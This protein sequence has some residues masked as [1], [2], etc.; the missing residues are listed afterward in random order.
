MPQ[1]LT[2]CLVLAGLV[3]PF[4]GMVERCSADEH[5]ARWSQPSQSDFFSEPPAPDEMLP[6]DF[7]LTSQPKEEGASQE[8]DLL[9]GL[10]PSPESA[11]P[12][13]NSHRSG[14]KRQALSKAAAGAY[15]DP[16]YDNDFNYLN[17]PCYDGCLLGERFK[18]LHLPCCDECTTLDLGGQYRL[19]FHDEMNMRGLGLTGQDDQFLLRRLRLYANWQVSENLR[20]YGE[21]LDARSDFEDLSPRP[22]EE[23]HHELQ[24]LFVDL[25]MFASDQGELWARPGRQ[26]LIYGSQRLISPLDW[27]NTRRTFDG[28]KIYYRGE[29]WN[30]DGFWV[31]PMLGEPQSLDSPD[32]TQELYALWWNYHGVENSVFDLFW[33]GYA[34]YDSPFAAANTFQFQTVG[35][36]WKT[37]HGQWLAEVEGG[38]Q[39][40]DFGGMNH[41]AGFFTIG[42]GR[43]M[44]NLPCQPVL[45]AYYD[46]ASG[47][48]TI[49][50]GFNQLFPLGHKY[51]GFMDFFAR[52]NIED[53]N[54][55]LETTPAERWKGVIWWHIFNLQDGN[56][57]AYRVNGLPYV[58]TPGGSQYLGQELDL[59]AI[60]NQTPRI[61]WL[62]G[63]SHFFTGD[64]FSTNPTTL[65][66]TGDAD[67]VYVQWQMNF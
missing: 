67:F 24:N 47:D 14:E 59:L 9:P 65:P 21:Y 29:D 3:A 31:R 18:Q 45:W 10:P 32:D 44:K 19:R 64:W 23:N 16:F 57:V 55:L 34:D 54:V 22:I 40:G 56:D 50:N 63:Y 13:A 5:A 42:V 66:H 48:D 25:R 30:L 37:E 41:S 1:R 26:E 7:M 35:G 58:T 61:S 12:S 43:N 2:Y 39:F 49:G 60:W 28:A 46:W 53:F 36:H 6:A 62:F 20:V 38:Y 8:Q 11:S 17:D 4:A 27:S 51:L 33:I 15:R 52:T